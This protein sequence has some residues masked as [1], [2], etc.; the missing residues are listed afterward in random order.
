MT[1]H[2]NEEIAAGIKS[3]FKSFCQNSN[4]RT[5][6]PS[7][8]N[9]SITTTNTAVPQTLYSNDTDTHETP[10]THLPNRL[11]PIATGNLVSQYN[12][13]KDTDATLCSVHTHLPDNQNHP[14]NNNILRMPPLLQANYK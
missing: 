4:S 8:E 3:T 2:Q 6:S 11:P 9:P 14:I 10:L 12:V 13:D 5:V 7:S 1:N